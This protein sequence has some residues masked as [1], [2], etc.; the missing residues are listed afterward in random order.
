MGSIPWSTEQKTLVE[1]NILGNGGR[2]N[3]DVDIVDDLNRT[4][5]SMIV[6][7]GANLSIS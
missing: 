2:S 5:E 7:K 4:K 1:A 3:I 6:N